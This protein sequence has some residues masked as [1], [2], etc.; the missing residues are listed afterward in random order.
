MVRRRVLL[1]AAIVLIFPTFARAQDVL[2]ASVEPS[3]AEEQLFQ[4]ISDS[5]DGEL[6]L[7]DWLVDV[8][9]Y[10]E[11]PL[12]LATSTSRMLARIPT[13][14]PFQ[15]RNLIRDRTSDSISSEFVTSNPVLPMNVS[16]R[17]RLV[18]DPNI[19]DE[20]GF[21]KGA[22]LG[23]PQAYYDVLRAGWNKFELVLLQSKGAGVQS[24][25]DRLNGYVGLRAPIELDKLSL[26]QLAV[27]DYRL[28]FGNGLAFGNIVN[29]L[30]TRQAVTGLDPH[31][32]GLEG[33]TRT[34]SMR[35][36]ATTVTLTSRPTNPG[37]HSHADVTLFY[38]DAPLDAS[39]DSSGITSII[40]SGYHRTLT[41]LSH[42]NDAHLEMYGAHLS[43]TPVLS[44]QI[45]SEFGLTGYRSR[46]SQPVSEAASL[47]AGAQR[48]DL[49]AAD[50]QLVSEDIAANGEIARSLNDF[51][52]AIAEAASLT[53]RPDPNLHVAFQFRNIPINYLNRNASVFGERTADGK[54]ENG[55]YLGLDW[56]MLDGM[57][58]AS[59]YTDL[60]HP[61]GSNLT[62]PTSD[63][64]A[65][66]EF[67]LPRNALSLYAQFHVKSKD[68][69]VRNSNLPAGA[70]E[71]GTR[72]QTNYLFE[73]TL[74][75][76]DK[77]SLRF[78]AQYVGVRHSS[79]D[80]SAQSGYLFYIGPHIELWRTLTLDA[81]AVLIHTT[82]Y[83]SRLYEYEPD[84]PG[85]NAFSP[86]H[87]DGWRAYL[88][89]GLQPSPQIKISAKYSVTQFPSVRIISSGVTARTGNAE[90]RFVLQSDLRF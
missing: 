88:L 18:T 7:D 29:S 64:L 68:E 16:L 28:G 3:S 25:T 13:L 32:S 57:L 9:S 45:L 80:S 26:S 31:T 52:S 86:L 11:F 23:S 62:N 40:S 22:F 83:D 56:K 78:Q 19:R 14:D 60:S 59:A 69:I 8:N 2:D 47:S 77:L 53:I 81:R 76:L 49:L 55:F 72:K 46:L 79:T 5:P 58:E 36:A 54:P 65:G 73:G 90:R 50:M 43:A 15:R 38:S 85:A 70:T 71:H 63:H 30:K 82:S 17:S 75:L 51:G 35:G 42:K 20:S 33:S 66:L 21:Q 61:G 27:G 34:G 4:A 39:I 84:V 74:K 10:A 48:E 41:E 12:L 6:I 89:A 1:L 67:T 24:F 37:L 44:D 87:G